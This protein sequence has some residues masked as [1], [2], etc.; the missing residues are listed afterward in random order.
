MSLKAKPVAQPVATPRRR[1]LRLPAKV[2]SRVGSESLIAA[3][4]D[5]LSFREFEKLAPHDW[6]TRKEWSRFLNISEK[7]LQ[8]YRQQGKSFDSIHS[9]RIFAIA[10][11]IENGVEVFGEPNRFKH[12]LAQ[13]NLALGRVCPKDFLDTGAGI[14]LVADQLG[15]IAHGIVA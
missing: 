10:S 15:R 5:G 3:I 12:W 1:Y 2:R 11:L 9:E 4:R 13:E 7:T 8:R 6:F 14:G